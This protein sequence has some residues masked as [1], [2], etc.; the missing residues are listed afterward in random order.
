[1]NNNKQQTAVEWLAETLRFAN[2]GLYAEMYE[3]IEQAKKMEKE[4]IIKAYENMNSMAMY[5][6]QYYN[7]TF[8][9]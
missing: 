9:K 8:N 4:Q 1:M 3:D 5:G 6:E 2:K 7:E